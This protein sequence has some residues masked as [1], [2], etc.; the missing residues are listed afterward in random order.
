MRRPNH[1]SQTQAEMR[2]RFPDRLASWGLVARAD[3]TNVRIVMNAP[4]SSHQ[5]R[6]RISGN[7]P[8]KSHSTAISKQ[9]MTRIKVSEPLVLWNRLPAFELEKLS[10]IE[11]RRLGVLH[12]SCHPVSSATGRFAIPR[13]LSRGDTSPSST[14]SSA[15]GLKVMFCGS[16]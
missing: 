12:G 3:N 14:P 4:G 5:R 8:T 15:H 2:E 11:S 6:G 1:Q 10:T 16:S 13:I 9:R 7:P